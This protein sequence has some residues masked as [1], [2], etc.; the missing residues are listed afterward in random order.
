MDYD[1]ILSQVLVLLQQQQRLSYRVL[2][3]RLQLDDD[4]LEALQEDLIYAKQVAVDEEGKVLVWTGDAGVVTILY[5]MI[6]LL[7]RL[8]LQFE[9]EESPEQKR[10]KLEGFLVQL[11][12][13]LAEAVPLFAALL[14][15]LLGADYAPLTVSPEQ[16]KQQTL[17]AL[18]TV[19]LRLAAQQPL[20]FVMEDLHWVDPTTLEFL[21]LLVD[22]GPTARI[23]AL[24]TCRPNFRPPW[25]GRAHLTQVTL[26]RL[27]RRQAAALTGRVAHGK[28]LPPEVIEQIVAK[29][30]GV[31]LFV[32]ELTKMLLESGFLQERDDR[33]E[34]TGPLP[35]LAI[36]TTLHD[37]LMARLDRLAAVKAL[38]QLGAT[39]GREFSYELLQAVAPWDEDT[40]HR[41]LQQLVTAEFLYQRGLPPQA[42]Y[43]FK[44]ALIQDA[45]YQSLLKS[46]RQ[47]YH[48]R[49]AQVLEAQFS[50]ATETRPELLAHHYT[51]AGVPAQA[52]PYWQRAGQRAI[53]R[54]APLE[55]IAHLSK[56]L[57][58][59]RTL[60]DSPERTQQ[61]LDMQLAL[62]QAWMAAKGQGVPE[63]ERAYTRARE[64]CQQVGET[65]ELF[66]VLL[67]L[68]R[69]YLVRAEYQ[70]AREL[71]EQC[72]SLAQRVHDPSLLLGAHY[73]LGATVYLLG[74]LT[75]ARAHLEQ[76]LALYDRQQ[77][78]Q[79]AFHYGM[80]LGVWCLSYVAWHHW[81]LGYP[82]QALTRS[83]EAL[84][85]AQE[86]SHP[87]SLRLLSTMRP[88]CIATA[89][90]GT[91]PRSGQRPAWRSPARRDS[92]SSWRWA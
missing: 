23:L 38:A 63:V 19:L 53:E 60:V 56:G 65:P 35:P 9:R 14:S 12:L 50:E 8:A 41:G 73:A 5:P 48:Q 21:S 25:T 79:L 13:P 45:A 85:L 31:P 78:H 59:L 82:E 62:G 51:E 87:H 81:L 57:E 4:T 7:E 11:G 28:A 22:Q 75:P 20:L 55:A 76:G 16:Q 36:P 52:L 24:F 1:A 70:T 54:A 42:T 89:G 83:H 10:R 84:T 68:W 58:I 26:N 6:E 39:L 29:T 33:Y 32:E 47:Q 27:P 40:L 92:R 64:L 88:S 44:H 15:L 3:L 43:L 66:P 37:S 71:A 30:D 2:K 46:T 91:L 72:L 17:H 77:H 18:L 61:E 74:E 80:D 67:G 34:L 86:L 69:F 49:I 90:R